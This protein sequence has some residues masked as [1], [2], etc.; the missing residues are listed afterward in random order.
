MNLRKF[1]TKS[2]E[3]RELIGHI[4]SESSQSAHFLRG[5]ETSKVL[6]IVW[7]PKED[8]FL[9]DPSS[10]VNLARNTVGKSTKRTFLSKPILT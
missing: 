5:T 7:R 3:L 6:G 4:S 8:I 2:P 1:D 9:F 10:I